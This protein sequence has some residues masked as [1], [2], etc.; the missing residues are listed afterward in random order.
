[1]GGNAK[2]TQK[3]ITCFEDGHFFMANEPDIAYPWLF[4]YIK[5]EEWRTQKYVREAV[6]KYFNNTTGGI[7]G[8][9]DC[10]T[11]STWL[12]YSMMGFYPD[13]PGN[14]E[15]QL[16]CPLFDKITIRLDSEYFPGKEF[17]I[18][19]KDAGKENIYIQSMKLNGKPYNKHTLNHFD[20]IK[21]GE[22]IIYAGPNPDL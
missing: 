20:I 11:M 2:F 21:G 12:M 22:L 10:G 19:V 9:D 14:I 6:I 15:Y 7:W 17:I 18:Q 1:M 13:C 8:N 5:G 4:N 3:L 16:S